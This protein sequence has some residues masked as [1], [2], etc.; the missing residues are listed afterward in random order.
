[1]TVTR[2]EL[3]QILK[4]I[5]ADCHERNECYGCKFELA[6]GCALRYIPEEWELRKLGLADKEDN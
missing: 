5:S 2:S 3:F 4:E 6:N 1:M